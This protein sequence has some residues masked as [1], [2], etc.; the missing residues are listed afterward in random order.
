MGTKKMLKHFQTYNLFRQYQKLTTLPV[1]SVVDTQ[2]II[3]ILEIAE[4]DDLLDALITNFEY[5]LVQEEGFL[6]EDYVEYYKQQSEKLKMLI[7]NIS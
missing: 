2:R 6:E 7:R 1:L 4:T 3:K 5:S